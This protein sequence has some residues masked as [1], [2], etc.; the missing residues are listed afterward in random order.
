[1]AK[2]PKNYLTL[3]KKYPE[4]IKAFEAAGKLAKDAGP[5]N[6]KTGHLIQLAACAAMRSEGGVHSHTRRALKAG[7]K[8]DEI[9]QVIA[10][11]INT[12]GFS[13]A[14]AAFSW[15]NDVAGKK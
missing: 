4:L 1:M 14:A 8:K 11:L 15:V 2:Y 7:A 13:N 12:I 3:Q 9:Y 6:E 10:L 5:V